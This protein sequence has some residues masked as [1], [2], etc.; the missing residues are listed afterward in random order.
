M[1]WYVFALVDAVPASRPGKGIGGA[2]SML[3]IGEAFAVVE[4]RADV[5]PVEFGSLE[6]HQDVVTRMASSVPAILPVRFGTLLE[7]DALE[8]ALVDRD[9]EI[10]AAFALVRGRVQ[11]TWRKRGAKRTAREGGRAAKRARSA[12]PDTFSAL[13]ASGTDYLRHAAR[14]AKPAPPAAWRALRSKLAPLVAAERY[15]PATATLPESLY[16]LVERASSVRY[17]TLAAGLGHSTPAVTMSGPWPPFAFAPE[18][19]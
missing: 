19:L 4:R 17:A 2:L 7:R 14:A 6:K 12:T 16:H 8:E 3:P 15:Q 9:D 5:P 11:F 13:A 1:A 18:L 10:A